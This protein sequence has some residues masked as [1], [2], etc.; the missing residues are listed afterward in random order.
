ML[1][2]KNYYSLDKYTEIEGILYQQNRYVMLV[3]K[4]SRAGT[5]K[6]LVGTEGRE[7]P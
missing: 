3:R 6:E 2:Q 4:P 5:P 7:L 1:L